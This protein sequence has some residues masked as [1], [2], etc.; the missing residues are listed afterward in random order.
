LLLGIR[1]LLAGIL[2]RVLGQLLL[3]ARD[4]L[5]P[6]GYRSRLLGQA[7]LMLRDLLLPGRLLR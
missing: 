5:L 2:G 6:P 7:L 4:L 3:L 1:L